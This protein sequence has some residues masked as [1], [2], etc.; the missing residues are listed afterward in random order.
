MYLV[1]GLG[2]PGPKYE[3]TRHNAGFRVADRL[4]T[5]WKISLDSGKFEAM[6][7]KGEA[8]GQPVLLCKPQ[9]FMNLS[10]TAVA[11]LQR[12][13]RINPGDV[14]VIHDDLDLET[15]RLRIRQGGSAG[16]QN[17]I[18]DIIGKMGPG[19][20]RVKVGIGR[21]PPGMDAAAY[22]L[23]APR[24]EE[25]Q[26]LETACDQAALAVEAIIEKGVAQA[27][28]LFNRR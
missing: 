1:A 2:N 3:K 19:F 9:T 25:E 26:K 4:S 11:G 20:V 23:Q 10:G 22:V 14:I 8:V 28:N 15:G 12:F 6:A 5:R 7:G 21:P 17:G 13:Y 24:G 16:G 27:M 18:K